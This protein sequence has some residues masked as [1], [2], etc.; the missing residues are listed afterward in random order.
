MCY[1]VRVISA[2]VKKRPKMYEIAKF[3]VF[4]KFA[5]K[6]CSLLCVNIHEKMRVFY[7]F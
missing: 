6:N 7:G 2:H 4:F 5:L 1:R 3:Y